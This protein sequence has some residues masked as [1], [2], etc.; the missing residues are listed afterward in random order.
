M[1]CSSSASAVVISVFSDRASRSSFHTASY[2]QHLALV[3]HVPQDAGQL[4]LVCLRAGRLLGEHLLA[5]G[6][7]ERLELQLGRLV[8]RADPGIADPHACPTFSK[9]VK[10]VTF[11]NEAI[12]N[13]FEKGNM[14][15]RRA[16]A[17]RASTIKK[18]GF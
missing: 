12:K 18:V 5:T 15:P 10:P 8:G 1:P 14:P 2:H 7:A 16:P 3:Q 11:R 17:A 6:V 4:G 9:A 13:G